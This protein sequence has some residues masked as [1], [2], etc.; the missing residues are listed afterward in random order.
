MD[1]YDWTDKHN[2]NITFHV[3]IIILVL[4]LIYFAYKT[5][6]IV[7][8]WNNRISATYGIPRNQTTSS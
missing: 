2:Q 1:K 3:I 8:K 7:T 6:S 4:V 5:Y